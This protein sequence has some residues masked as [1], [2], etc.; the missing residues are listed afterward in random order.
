MKETKALI[1]IT[2]F[3]VRVGFKRWGIALIIYIDIY[4]NGRA[5]QW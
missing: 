2:G 5:S 1:L 4:V 3:K